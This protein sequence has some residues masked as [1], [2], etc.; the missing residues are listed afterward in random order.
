MNVDLIVM[1]CGGDGDGSD[2]CVIQVVIVGV[3]G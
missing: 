3:V 1:V 2:M